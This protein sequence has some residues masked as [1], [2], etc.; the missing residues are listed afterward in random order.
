MI[1]RIGPV[2]IEFFDSVEA[3]AREKGTLLR[4]LPANGLAFLNADDP[5]FPILR[6]ASRARVV[7]VSSKQSADYRAAI[8]EDGGVLDV[9]ERS[10]L[11][12][13]VT[14]PLPGRH[15]AQN[16]LLALAVGRE[17][18]LSPESI[19]AS[20]QGVRPPPMR[21]DVSDVAGVQV[22]NDAYNANPLSMRAALRAFAAAYAPEQSWLAL[23]GMRELGHIAR[24]EHE[25]LGREIGAGA[26]AGL[27]AIGALAEGIAAGAIKAG[28][29]AE[30]IAICPDHES[31]AS[32]LAARVRPGN[33]ALFKASRGERLELALDL[34]RK[35]VCNPET[36]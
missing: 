15:N 30:R 9:E 21:W 25:E 23:G 22:V 3:I 19:Q 28:M 14:V 2:H 32:E 6:E 27:I 36:V 11:R 33:A 35:K 26:W 29:Q 20:L 10:G 24:V 34:W 1:T 4:A 5:F 31:A 13:R 18:G 7:S 16:A 17:R 8:P 12:Y